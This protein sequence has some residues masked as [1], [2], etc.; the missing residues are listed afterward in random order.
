MR[1]CGNPRCVRPDIEHVSPADLL[2]PRSPFRCPTSCSWC[3]AS[4]APLRLREDAQYNR[5]WRACLECARLHRTGEHNALLDRAV[6]HVELRPHLA[7]LHAE[8]GR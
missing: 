5:P 7:A 3:G 6:A 2:L 4:Y 1:L 8:A